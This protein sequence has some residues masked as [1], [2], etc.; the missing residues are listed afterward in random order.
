MI[1]REWD[2]S[3]TVCKT[4]QYCT[5]EDQTHPASFFSRKATLL[6][7]MADVWCDNFGK[8]I[9]RFIRQTIATLIWYNA[10]VR[11]CT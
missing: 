1:R 9:C 8:Q 4:C 5:I 7:Q 11:T 6:S 3:F 10:A 2:N